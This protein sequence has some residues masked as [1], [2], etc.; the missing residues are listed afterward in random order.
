MKV[1]VFYNLSFG[2]AKRVVRE[3]VKGL[4]DR[5]HTID[6]YTTDTETDI[7]DP[8]QF[9]TKSYH[10]PFQIASSVP[11]VSRFVSDI[12]NFYLL[13]NHHRKI[14][15]DID[16]R[17]YDCV[18]VHPDKLTQ[19]PFL[20]RFLKTP[21]LYYCQEPLR[22]VY[23]YGFRLREQVGVL[24]RF[25]EEA[26]RLYRKKIDRENVRSA[27]LSLASCYH[28]RERM[29]EAYDV[30][31]KVSYLGV[32]TKTFRPLRVKKKN[33]VFF[34][35]SKTLWS[36]G[37][38]LAEKA[39]QLMDRSLRPSLRVVSWKKQDS[40][41]LSEDELVR[42]YNESIATL[43]MSRFETFGLVPL[44]SMA[45]GTPVIATTVSGHRETVKDGKTGFLVDFD[46]EQIAK[47]LTLLI[48]NR[49]LAKKIGKKARAYTASEW[50]WQKR[51]DELELL[52]KDFLKRNT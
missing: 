15:G 16:K 18:L 23:E 41:R 10:Y 14:A 47:T 48:T 6:V 22:I 45:S 4:S 5:G 40:E 12:K 9:A 21:S 36:D 25:Y 28:I 49:E 3:H 30:F 37:Y 26:T 44:E 31:P 35:G 20:L 1:A 43:C 13:K 11:F 51:L 29:I 17:K 34:V 19:A 52:L 32:D 46:P 2:G 39:I 8:A 42:M 7:F 27:T 24:N 38:D 50:S 33:E